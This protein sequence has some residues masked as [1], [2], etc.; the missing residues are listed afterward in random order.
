[1]SLF[2]LGV[3]FELL[4]ALDALQEKNILTLLLLLIMQWSFV[5]YSALL[6]SQLI[7]AVRGSNADV[8]DVRYYSKAYSIVIPA[9]IAGFTVAMM[10]LIWRLYGE[11]G[12]NLYKTL[13]ADLR[14][15][16]M[17]A[18]YQGFVCLLKVLP[19]WDR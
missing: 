18:Q 14:T 10:W 13:G 19:S 17:Y 1:M 8:P 9:V 6:P 2:I 11:F 3:V 7:T 12:W 15:K 4:V 16:R 5:V